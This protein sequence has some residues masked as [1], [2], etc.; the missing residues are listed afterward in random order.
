MEELVEVIEKLFVPEKN[1][2]KNQNKF[3]APIETIEIKD[4]VAKEDEV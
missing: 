3:G 1:T 4:E 2:K